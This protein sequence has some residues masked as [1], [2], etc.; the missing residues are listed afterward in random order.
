LTTGH[1]EGRISAFPDSVES[2]LPSVPS[3]SGSRLR[4]LLL[5]LLA[6]GPALPAAAGEEGLRLEVL[7]ATPSAR[8]VVGSAGDTLLS[9]VTLRVTGPDGER[10]AGIPV[11][12]HPSPGESPAVV[13]LR[14]RALTDADGELRVSL[15]LPG[16]PGDHAFFAFVEGEPQSWVEVP[17][18][19]LPRSWF[20]FL[21]VGI[22]GG[23]ALFLYGMRLIGRGLEKAAGGRF[24][25]YLSSATSNNFRSLVF[26]TFSTLMVQSSSASTVLL[27]SF[28]GS[29][30]VTLEQALAAAIGAAVGSTFTVQLVAFRISDFALLL[31]AAGVPLTMSRGRR[32]RIGGVIFG[33]GLI[34]YGMQVMSE[35]MAPL[36]G[37]PVVTEFFVRAARDPV[38]ALVAAAVFTAIAQAS[39]ATIGLVL[40]LAFQGILSLEAALPFVLGANV[41]TATTALLASVTSNT[42]G[43]RVAWAHA[44]F[45]LASVLLALPFLGPL[46]SLV[47]R[48]SSDL[49]RQVAHAHTLVNL[50]AAVVFFPLIPVAARLFR[51]LVPEGRVKDEFLPQSLD[52]RFHEQPSIALAGAV[53]EVLRMGQLV[54]GM[55]DD[56]KESLQRHT[57][58]A[59][60]TITSIGWTR[61]SRST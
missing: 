46:A 10:V 25:D 42:E 29:G 37:M 4:P 12:L 55:L 26:G 8:L 11:L 50:A 35:A 19:I 27:V 21:V 34:F 7:F 45:R 9:H 20:G 58:S 52:P 2:R 28:A 51:T 23:L 54:I 48:L 38:P 31:V 40:G 33:F 36:R 18:R 59:G 49:P 3:T 30:L 41:G 16:S 39:A 43:K 44:A 1:A 56:V 17:V 47:Q 13:P 57:R 53:R 6:A 24:R 14:E 5:A 15:R 61:R 32:R 22:G 60:A